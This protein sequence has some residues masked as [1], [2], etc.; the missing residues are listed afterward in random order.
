[1]NRN[2]QIAALEKQ[3]EKL[4]NE[5]EDIKKQRP[6]NVHIAAKAVEQFISQYGYSFELNRDKYDKLNKIA[7]KLGYT[8]KMSALRTTFLF[9][10]YWLESSDFE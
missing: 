10:R 7:Q 5:I 1:M 4:L 3:V 2:K 6:K 8:G 9:R